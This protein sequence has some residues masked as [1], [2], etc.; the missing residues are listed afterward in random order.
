LRT[1]STL[2]FHHLPTEIKKLAMQEIYR[3]LRQNGRFVLADLG[4]PEGILLN[5]FFA[6]GAMIQSD[7]AK[8]I[9]D[10]KEGKLPLFLEEVGF[11][12]K[13]VPPRHRGIPFLLATKS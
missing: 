8:Y 10:N 11:E 5:T 7:E 3:I 9:Q 6:L 12:V 1:V 13:E 4:K 2:I